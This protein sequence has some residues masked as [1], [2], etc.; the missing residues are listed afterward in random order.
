MNQNSNEVTRFL[1]RIPS[2]KLSLDRRD[3]LAHLAEL[4][5]ALVLGSD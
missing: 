4:V 2:G 1:N 5:D 3:P